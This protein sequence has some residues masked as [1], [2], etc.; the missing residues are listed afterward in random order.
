MSRSTG[1]M[2]SA[3]EVSDM[4]ADLAEST[5]S[6]EGMVFNDMAYR[7][8]LIRENGKRGS[9]NA[10]RRLSTALAEAKWI[11]L[12]VPGNGVL[13]FGPEHEEA[14]QAKARLGQTAMEEA[15]REIIPKLQAL[16]RGQI[17]I[18]LKFHDL[19]ML[20]GMGTEEEPL[21]GTTDEGRQ[22]AFALRESG[23][24]RYATEGPHPQY[25]GE[26]SFTYHWLPPTARVVVQLSPGDN[27]SEA[28]G[29]GG[30]TSGQTGGLVNRVLML[31]A[32]TAVSAI[33]AVI[34][35]WPER[36]S[37]EGR[38]SSQRRPEPQEGT[39][40]RGAARATTGRTEP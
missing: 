18:G 38:S 6:Q 39:G 34:A 25:E 15:G 1:S 33:L 26:H 30:G 9:P 37:G 13:W 11:R 36:E 22:L 10:N 5:A 14:A 7:C 24:F 27:G 3:K 28:A 23:W 35:L 2:P 17:G 29:E 20:L 8:G 16:T 4:L 32:F 12:N 40:R 31:L 21:K 19:A